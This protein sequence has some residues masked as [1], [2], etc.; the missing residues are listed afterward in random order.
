MKYNRPTSFS[1]NN[2]F[3]SCPRT[4]YMKYIQKIPGIEDLKYAHRG[5]VVHHIL[6][7]YYPDKKLTIPEMKDMFKAEWDGFK[8]DETSL[9][10]K[11]D[12]TWLMVLAG[13]NLD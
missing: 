6:E 4:W 5:N 10:N 3:A 7:K 9:K 8:L 11:R 2:L 13:I 12:E 1:Q